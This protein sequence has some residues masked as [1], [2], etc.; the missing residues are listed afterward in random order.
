MTDLHPTADLLLGLLAWLATTALVELVI[1][2]A[3]FRL[4]HRADKA[5]GDRLPDLK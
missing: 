4:Y 3:M 1:K 2:P 5:T